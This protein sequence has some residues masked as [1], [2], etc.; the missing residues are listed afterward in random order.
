M[1]RAWYLAPDL[2]LDGTSNNTANVVGRK[3]GLTGDLAERKAQYKKRKALLDGGGV[4]L[5]ADPINPKAPD[6]DPGSR[7][8]SGP[9]GTGGS[10]VPSFLT[11]SAVNKMM[12]KMGYTEGGGLGAQG[13]GISQAIEV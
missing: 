9:G 8:G 3:R 7:P 2:Y 6:P 1:D 12:S 10:G 5:A 4:G 11:S 13:Q